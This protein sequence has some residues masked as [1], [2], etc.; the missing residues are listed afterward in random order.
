M[1][2]ENDNKTT[3]GLT[4]SVALRLFIGGSSLL[5]PPPSSTDGTLIAIMYGPRM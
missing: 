5:S 4:N 2:E 3:E 1:D